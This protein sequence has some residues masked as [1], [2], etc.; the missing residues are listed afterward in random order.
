MRR[1]P[2][3]DFTIP[4][5]FNLTTYYLE[6]NLLKGRGENIAIHY[7]D[8]TYTYN[9]LL[10]LTNRVGNVFKN[11]GLHVEDRVLLVLQ[12]SP[13]W[14]ASWLATMKVG[15][16]ATH[17]YTYL[18]PSEY[19]YFL[20]YIRPRL[21][22][23]DETTLERVREGAR[24][25]KY[26]KAMLVAGEKL[27]ELRKGEYSLRELIEKASPL[28]EAEPT[29]R[30]DVAHWNFSGGT[31][32]KQKGVPHMHHDGIAGFESYQYLW[33]VTP[34]DVVIRIPK[35]FFHYARDL[36]MNW[37]LRAG[38]SLALSRER[39]T[40]ELVFEMI[41]KY[42]P[43]IVLNVPTMMRAMIESPK[44]KGADLSCVRLSLATG[45]ALSADLFKEFYDKFGVEVLNIIGSAE[46][47]L[48]YLANRPGKV[49]PGSLGTVTP[50]VE[51]K[52][53]DGD[54]N[55]ASEGDPG[56]LWVR[57]ESSGWM[58]HRDHEK[59]KKTFMGSDWINTGDLFRVDENGYFWFLGRADDLI[60]VSGVWVAPFEIEKCLEKHP[61]V[62][63]CAVVGAK[64]ADDLLKTKAY[65]ALREGY[66]PSE[67]MVRELIEFCRVKMSPF[68]VPRAMEF[69]PELPKMLPPVNNKPTFRR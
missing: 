3:I 64:D 69:L 33:K 29:S 41:E 60:K 5:Q 43:T 56:V 21:V 22:I 30:D 66:E 55:E 61:A 57:S 59:T 26:P 68:K 65:V 58:Y 1:G 7:E 54:G 32:G 12:D 44:A 67:A 34:D 62:R 13:E 51:A 6:E 37:P 11:L 38:A 9:E 40:A 27:P 28:L 39:T 4:D 45:E 23:V 10:A 20:N 31:T 25:S 14:V 53:V 36:G 48:G 47:L 63:E 52:L 35:L 8:G 24:N 50:L 49:V 19:E 2:D 17:A 18:Q 42:R 15:G 46:A 16:V